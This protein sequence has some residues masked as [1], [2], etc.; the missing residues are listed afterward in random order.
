M[1]RK[2]LLPPSILVLAVRVEQE[3]SPVVAARPPRLLPLRFDVSPHCSPLGRE[4]LLVVEVEVEGEA[5]RGGEVDRR[6][7]CKDGSTG[8]VGPATIRTISTI[9]RGVMTPAC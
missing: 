8:P 4:G 1:Q 7:S 3:R 2:W 6:W 9:V 5:V